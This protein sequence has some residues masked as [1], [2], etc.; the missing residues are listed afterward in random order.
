MVTKVVKIGIYKR[1][2]MEKFEYKLIN[3]DTKGFGAEMYK[4]K[5]KRASLTYLEMM[6]R[7]WLAVHPLTKATLRP[8]A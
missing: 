6:D 2:K 5:R 4:F 3:Y 1:I 8:K 7:K